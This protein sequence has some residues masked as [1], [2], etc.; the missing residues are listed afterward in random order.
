MAGFGS[1]LYYGWIV[2]ALTFI[3]VLI[4]S[5]VRSSTT[6]FIVPLETE[7]DWSRAAISAAISL[8]L[9]LYG[10][11]APISGWLMDRFGP[12]KVVLGSLVLLVL[13]VA[14]T[15]GM[16]QLWQLTLL[17][18][19]LIGLG[20]GGSSS[21]LYATV[22][23]RWFVAR[24]GLVLGFLG[25]ANSTGQLL[26]LPALMAIIVGFGWR[27]G[28]VVMVAIV[29]ALALPVL[30]W[31]RDDPADIGL[32]PYGADGAEA[33]R[34]AQPDAPAISLFGA[35]RTPDFWLLAGAYFVCGATSGGL[36]GTHFIPHSIDHGIPEMTAAATFGVMGGMN[37]VGTIGAG[38]LTDRVD[39]RKLLA[40]IYGLRGLSLFALPFLT[41]FSGLAVFAVVYGL[42]WFA[43]VPP[44]VAVTARRF[45]RGSMGSIYGW[46]FASHQLGA[47]VLAVG[48]GVIRVWMGDY[49]LAF[50]AG[51]VLG[52]LAAGMS[53]LVRTR[54]PSPVL[55]P[56]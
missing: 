1:R 52:L 25:S 19:I 37:F 4:T 21:V 40:M 32:R 15:L 50:L 12:R 6:V 7:F 13:G 31:M 46:I 14:G 17:W 22:A 34:A 18:G 28:S 54:R 53:L 41:D 2:V 16:N 51:G 43:T 33:R 26:F 23:S 11:A 38:W 5:G 45:G 24:R 56:A 10:L 30:L 39:P 8:N 47:A 29:L 44:T 35:L 3:T 48:G 49:Q 55:A 36:I 9:L 27:G 20:A 42:D